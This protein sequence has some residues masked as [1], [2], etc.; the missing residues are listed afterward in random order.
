VLIGMVPRAGPG[1]AKPTP[2]RIA[3]ATDILSF[4]VETLGV[5]GFEPDSGF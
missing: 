1:A 3:E 5:E 2:M 4:L